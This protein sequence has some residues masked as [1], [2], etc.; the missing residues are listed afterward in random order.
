MIDQLGSIDKVSE[1]D[2]QTLDELVLVFLVNGDI[3]RR[4]AESISEPFY[5]TVI[6]IDI[7]L[8][9]H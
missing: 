3:W 7:M 1:V 8:V 4:G 6:F 9:H 2:A 5:L